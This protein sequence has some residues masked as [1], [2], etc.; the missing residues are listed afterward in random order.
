MKPEIDI[1]YTASESWNEKMPARL[2]WLQKN[3]PVHW[4]EKDQIWLLTKFEDVSYVSKNHEIF[5]SGQGVRPPDASELKIGFIDEDEPRHGKMRKWINKGFTPRMVAKLEPTFRQIV[6]ETLDA[7]A[8]QSECDFVDD[9]AVPVPLLLIA[10]MMGIRKE[11]RKRFHHWSDTMIAADGNQDNP[12]IMMKA[13][14]AYMEY[15]TYL[16]EIFEER[17]KNP[18]DDLIS[19]LVDAEAKG[20]LVEFD[21]HEVH[22][23]R[24]E[25]EKAAGRSELVKICVALLIAG[26]ETTRNAIS[27]GMEQLIRNPDQRQRL[28]DDPSLIPT[29]A[30]E[31]VRHVSPV[32]SFVRTAT[33]DT[34]LR[35]RPIKKGERVFMLYTAA[36]RDPE[37]FEDPDRFDIAR[38]PA[39]LGFGIG[40]HFCLGANLARM[41]L[42]VTFE[43]LLRRLP[44]ME[45]SRGGPELGPNAL[46]RSCTHMWVKYSPEG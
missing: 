9:I 1:N 3:D 41:E 38:D 5:C 46:V 13:A 40:N 31:I 22:K 18:Q 45:F 4:S 26:N 15:A 33:R 42:R 28:I 34:E 32:R 6:T 29:A 7:V 11:D 37:Q 10:E 17:R 23:D 24:S 8:Q 36:N 20:M 14:G 12:E 43:E 21:L 39:H 44:D 27:G 35:G 16:T 25:E 19:I 2:R 30:E